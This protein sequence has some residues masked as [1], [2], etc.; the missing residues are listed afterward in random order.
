MT[1]KRSSLFLVGSACALTLI[2]SLISCSPSQKP[3][4]QQQEI[5]SFSIPIPQDRTFRHYTFS[6]TWQHGFCAKRQNKTPIPC[7]SEPINAPYIG[8]HGLWASTPYT[9]S[10]ANQQQPPISWWAKGCALYQEPKEEPSLSQNMQNDLVPLMPKGLIRHEYQKHMQCFKMNAEQIFSIEEKLHARILQGPWGTF[11]LAHKNEEIDKITLL[12]EF[13]KYYGT[14]PP[15]G[16]QF[17][18]MKDPS[19]QDFVTEF[20]FTLDPHKL[21]DFPKNT[22]FLSSLYPQDN[23]PARFRL[24]L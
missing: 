2:L 20:W 1:L 18:C 23:C 4:P 14:L 12:T 15:R 10:E 8:I 16:L 13:E 11:V 7:P 6:L 9:L 19:G 24:A 17:R 3:T 5:T 21:K 22:A